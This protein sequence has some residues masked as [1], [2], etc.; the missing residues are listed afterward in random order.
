MVIGGNILKACFSTWQLPE[1]GYTGHPLSLL[2]V[3]FGM[4]G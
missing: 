2:L 1:N 3:E 4:N